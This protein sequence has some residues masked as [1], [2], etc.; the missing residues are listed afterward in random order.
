MI[1]LSIAIYRL[2]ID[3]AIY[4]IYMGS[5]IVYSKGILKI[6]IYKFTD[7]LKKINWMLARI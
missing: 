1:V 5:W 3:C 7:R 4:A 6:Q 2:S